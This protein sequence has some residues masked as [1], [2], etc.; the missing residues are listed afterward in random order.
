M[1]VGQ[2]LLLALLPAIFGLCAA[3]GLAYYG[4]YAR[5]APEWFVAVALVSSTASLV[6][7]WFATRHVAQRIER[8]VALRDDR[9][10]S[11]A[12]AVAALSPAGDALLSVGHDHDELDAIQRTV[13]AL[14]TAY[15]QV[16]GEALTLQDMLARER[17]ERSTLVEDAATTVLRQ[18]EDVR[19]PLHILLENRFGD[20]NENQEEMLGA[21]RAAAEAADHAAQRLRDVA[22][23]DLGTLPVRHD[24]VRLADLLA[25]IV[26]GLTE[27]LAA[28]GL[29]LEVAVAPALPGLGGDR[30]RVQDV[31][32]AMVLE[33]A[34]DLPAGKVVRVEAE[35]SREAVQVVVRGA[36]TAGGVASLAYARRVAA[37]HGGA[38]ATD[39][40]RLVLTLPRRSAWPT[41]A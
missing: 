24:H 3:V 16:R 5:Q 40:E 27:Q 33:A 15:L 7:A 34:R 35:A 22:A 26:P 1:R 13:D 2:R 18:L 23:L 21:A 14:T 19:L 9:E 17:D 38:L 6:V 10:G 39:G 25:T 20:L 4:E 11:L 29:A 30:E 36:R 41:V 28:R 31:L 37:A 8:L 12:R 32:A